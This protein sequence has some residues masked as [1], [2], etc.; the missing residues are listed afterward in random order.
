VGTQIDTAIE[1]LALLRATERANP[2]L[3][4]TIEPVIEQLHELA[5]ATVPRATAAR[6]LN[7]SQPALDRWINL[8][9]VATV[10]TP[11]GRRAVPVEHLVE[12]LNDVRLAREKG[13]QRALK[14]VIDERRRRAATIELDDILETDELASVGD[15]G[16]RRA[17]LTSLAYHRVVGHQLDEFSVRQARRRLR[18]WT[19]AGKMPVQYAAAWR[20]LL[21]DSPR[22]ELVE[23]ISTDSQES[24]DLRQN[25]PF[26]AALSEQ[27]RAR[28]LAL[29]RQWTPANPSAV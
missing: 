7:V 21:E 5:G 8:G 4:E 13:H 1:N 11:A 6:L 20:S 22:D 3:A 19:A 26:A 16:H 24:R 12:L 14:T 10:L 15:H 2:E 23:I 27:E 28:L 18:S 29:I 17:E 25:T 9:E